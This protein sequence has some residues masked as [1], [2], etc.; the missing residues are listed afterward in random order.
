MDNITVNFNNRFINVQRDRGRLVDR[1]NRS[2]CRKRKRG[3]EESVAA[4]MCEAVR[5]ARLAHAL[6]YCRGC[7]TTCADRCSIDEDFRPPCN[8][9]R[10][11]RLGKATID[12]TDE[13]TDTYLCSREPYITRS[14][15][16]LLREATRSA[17]DFF[18]HSRHGATQAGCLLREENSGLDCNYQRRDRSPE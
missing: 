6:L 5:L 11:A 7:R 4:T 3:A 1:Q 15:N 16:K 2:E 17:T 8:G 18:L 12:R 14:R 13:W 9:Q 10:W